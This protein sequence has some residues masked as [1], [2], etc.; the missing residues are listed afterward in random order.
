MMILGSV[1]HEAEGAW[2]GCASGSE[3]IAILNSFFSW[4][5]QGTARRAATKRNYLRERVYVEDDDN[6]AAPVWV[7][8]IT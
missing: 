4:P 1:S 2:R 7:E 6:L 3:C 8:P 5:V